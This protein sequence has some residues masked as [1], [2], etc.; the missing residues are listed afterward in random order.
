MIIIDTNRMPFSIVSVNSFNHIPVFKAS[1]ISIQGFWTSENNSVITV[2]QYIYNIDAFC[3]DISKERTKNSVITVPQYMYNNAAF[4]SDISKERKKSL[5][6][7][8]YLY[9]ILY[10]A[11][12]VCSYSHMV[13]LWAEYFTNYHNL[14]LIHRLSW[15]WSYG[16]WIYNYPCNQCLSPL[17]LWVRIPLRRG[18]LNTTLCDKVTCNRSVVFSRYSSFLHQ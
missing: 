8:L 18:V 16:S 1:K 7:F 4:C 11:I 12:H 14:H 9:I 13:D 10:T 3:S 5:I 17:T 6:F 2:P 15:P